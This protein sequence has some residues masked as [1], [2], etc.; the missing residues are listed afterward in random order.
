MPFPRF[1]S[2]TSQTR[3]P[4]YCDDLDCL[5]IWPPRFVS[6][7]M[8]RK[9]WQMSFYFFF[10]ITQLLLVFSPFGLQ[11]YFVIWNLIA[12]CLWC[13]WLIFRL[14]HFV[15]TNILSFSLI[16]I[17]QTSLVG[18]NPGFFKFLFE[19]EVNIGSNLDYVHACRM[20]EDMTHMQ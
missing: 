6:I 17:K 2:G 20:K 10:S 18:A 19:R 4:I 16:Q 9:F 11:Q 14:D 8:I 5:A 1:K 7:N 12:K 15:A 3:E 13:C